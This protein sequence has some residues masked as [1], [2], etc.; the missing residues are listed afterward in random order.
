MGL[1]GPVGASG[2]TKRNKIGNVRCDPGAG[3]DHG[4]CDF[5]AGFVGQAAGARALGQFF[6]VNSRKQESQFI[7]GREGVG[8][9]VKENGYFI[10]V[11]G[12][13]DKLP[14]KGD[15]GS[16]VPEVGGIVNIDPYLRQIADMVPDPG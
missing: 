12:P 6:Y 1:P 14:H 7:L 16:L 3:S 10:L 15:G 13:V 2:K 5:M 4:K 8:V 11:S 9:C